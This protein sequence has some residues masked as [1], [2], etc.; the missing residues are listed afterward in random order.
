MAPWTTDKQLCVKYTFLSR[1]VGV[2]VHIKLSMNTF[3]ALIEVHLMNLIGITLNVM[4]S[5]PYALHDK[6]KQI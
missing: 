6:N 3:D 2:S 1:P 5:R 4:N